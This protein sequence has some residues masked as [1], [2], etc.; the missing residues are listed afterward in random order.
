[1]T[2]A[3]L[4]HL[5]DLEGL[6]E[7]DWLARLDD[8]G[9]AHGDFAQLGSRHVAL[10]VDAGRQLLVTFDS[11]EEARRRSGALPLGLDHVTRNGWSVLAMI[12]RGDTWFRDP[13]VW[14]HMDRLTDDGFFEEFDRV[15]FFGAG[16]GGYAAAAFAVASPGAQVLAIRPYATLDPALAGWDRRH[17]AA[18]R[19]D[20]TSRYGF[21][22][23]M[24]QGAARAWILHDP[25]QPLDA[26]HAALFHRSN[27]LFLPCRQGGARLDRLL[28]E[29]DA[30]PR[31]LDL[32]MEGTLDRAAFGR[33]WRARRRN[34]PYLRTLLRTLETGKRR[35]QRIIHLCRFGL[36]TADR[37]FYERKLAAIEPPRAT[38]PQS[39]AKAAG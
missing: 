1:M 21:A 9:D 13:A 29:V 2:I 4:D 31:L 5:T 3:A 7:Q 20:W 16:P 25:A 36:S 12:S 15:L 14:R 19:W 39:S 8:L 35:P 33:L 24:L 30:L 17:P 10:S 34:L 11:L 18:R 22:P 32:A 37:P 23:D 26:M 28:Q 38:T 6:S 27:V